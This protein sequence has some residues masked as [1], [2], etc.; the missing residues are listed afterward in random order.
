MSALT[1]NQQLVENVWQSALEQLNIGSTEI[2]ISPAMEKQI[3]GEG[4]M[5]IADRFR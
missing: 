4:V 3:G 1:F 2:V 5:N